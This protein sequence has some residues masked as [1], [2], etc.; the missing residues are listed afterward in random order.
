MSRRPLL[1]DVLAERTRLREA[2]ELECAAR[3][4]A[5]SYVAKRGAAIR[6]LEE[7]V[8]ILMQRCAELQAEVLAV[9]ARPC[10]V[11]PEK[12][13]YRSVLADI[14]SAMHRLGSGCAFGHVHEASTEET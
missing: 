4:T 1:A 6:Q 8:A 7:A 3:Q 5:D 9:R 12:E 14:E 13:L 2:L 11:E 10:P